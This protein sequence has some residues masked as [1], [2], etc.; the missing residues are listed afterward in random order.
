MNTAQQEPETLNID[1]HVKELVVK[2][3]NTSSNQT[4]AADKLKVSVS[5]L[6]RY[7]EFYKLKH[8]GKAWN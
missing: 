6:Q 5:S 2:A 4:E 1:H 7:I 3:M 8:I